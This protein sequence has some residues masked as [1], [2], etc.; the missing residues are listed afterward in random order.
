MWPLS[1]ASSIS[2]LAVSVD[3]RGGL[4]SGRVGTWAFGKADKGSIA[5]L[6]ASGSS[7]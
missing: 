3:G 7:V 5:V 2:K 4:W 1:G 6:E